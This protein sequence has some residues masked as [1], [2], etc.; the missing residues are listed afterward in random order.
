MAN[1][2]HRRPTPTAAGR[3][4]QRRAPAPA[5]TAPAPALVMAAATGARDACLEPRYVYFFIY[6]DWSSDV[7]SSDLQVNDGQRR[8]MQ[9]HNSSLAGGGSRR[10]TSRA[11]GMFCSFTLL[12]FTY[13]YLDYGPTRAN[14]S[15]RQPMETNENPTYAGPRRPTQANDGQRGPP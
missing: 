8:P 13:I 2:D 11:A 6:R 12:Y 5:A 7:C 4:R 9:T 3:A 1:E 10:D 14:N 15:Q